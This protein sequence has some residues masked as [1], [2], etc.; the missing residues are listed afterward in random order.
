MSRQDKLEEQLRK[1][2][3]NIQ[4]DHFPGDFEQRLRTSLASV[5]PRK[6]ML[7]TN[8]FI[9]SVGFSLATLLIVFILLGSFNYN[10]FAYYGKKIVG[11][12][13]LVSE[14]IATLHEAGE[15]QQ[16]NKTVRMD[17][18]TLFIIDA[19]VSDE[20]QFILYYRL[21]NPDGVPSILKE[22]FRINSVTGFLTDSSMSHG[23]GMENE[24]GTEVIFT[25][26]FEPVSPWAKK[27]K[28]S[29][30][31]S[32]NDISG[33][34]EYREVEIA[35]NPK[36]AMATKLKK[37]I[38]KKAKVDEGTIMFKE[39][40]ATPTETIIKGKIK[41][42][43]YTSSF[44]QLGSINLIVDDIGLEQE[45]SG[46]KT[47]IK[48]TTFELRYAALPNDVNKLTIHIDKFTGYVELQEQ[49]DMT[50]L[51][52]GEESELAVG[53]ANTNESL[54][55][56]NISENSNHIEMDIATNP[57][58]QL[59]HVRLLTNHGEIELKSTINEQWDKE[60][61]G[62]IMK[63][64]TLVFEPGEDMNHSIEIECLNIGGMYW[65]KPYDIDINIPL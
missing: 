41:G 65:N 7:F 24:D 31:Q 27:L 52:N 43:T 59:L 3:N 19:L 13:K 64:R 14:H 56:L 36:L 53:L 58:I 37:R 47:D 49:I 4:I 40:I 38:N 34:G 11:Y 16:I 50:S 15:G 20:N 29:Y 33:T 60:E 54:Y 8:V 51:I 46:L 62:S 25:Q 2:K 32:F 18:G 42:N 28:L 30:Y 10:A 12:E 61:D 63:Y 57:D 26:S 39:I 44:S 5:P 17:D 23:T 45:G 1:L 22:S 48:G 55:I 35:Y 6:R 9:K 21:T